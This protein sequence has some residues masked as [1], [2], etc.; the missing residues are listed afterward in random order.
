MESKVEVKFKTIK[1]KHI[2]TK[3]NPD[4]PLP[5]NMIIKSS[6]SHLYRFGISNQGV[7]HYDETDSR[8]NP[9]FVFA[10]NLVMC[11]KSV[12]SLYYNDEENEKLFIYVLDFSF[13]IPGIRIH[14]NVLAMMLSLL[15]MLSQILHWYVCSSGKNSWLTPFAMMSGLITPSSIG[16]INE[17]DV[18]KLLKRSKL[19]FS[20]INICCNL[21][22]PVFAFIIVVVT[23]AMNCSARDFIIFGLSS[24]LIFSIWCHLTWTNICWHA[25]YFHITCHYFKL[26]LL[27]QNNEVKSRIHNR[28]FLWDVTGI[29]QKFDSIYAEIDKYNREFWSK[30]IF[31]FYITIIPIIVAFLYQSIF[32]QVDL[33]IRFSWYYFTAAFLLCF[34]LFTLSASSIVVES[35]RSYQL[36]I[37]YSM[38]IRRATSL[39][40]MKVT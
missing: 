33:T 40:L 5:E 35:N 38:N 29:I 2:K 12:I 6:G 25:A 22:I 14:F 23:M 3:F 13:F 18:K 15:T 39:K 26:K 17:N 1:I 21:I 28:K 34:T 20:L 4:H 37:Q 8:F 32:G 9:K 16:I 10:I 30:F 27:N 36:L 11:I 31:I 19:A 7:R 24:S